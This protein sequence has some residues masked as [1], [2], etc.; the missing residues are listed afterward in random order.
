MCSFVYQ[1]IIFGFGQNILNNVNKLLNKLYSFNFFFNFRCCSFVFLFFTALLYSN[2]S[3]YRPTVRIMKY[4]Q[5]HSQP[6]FKN[7]PPSLKKF[8]ALEIDLQSLAFPSPVKIS[9]S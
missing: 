5:L 2:L 7:L 4:F 9:D 1:N 6:K 8:C 3:S